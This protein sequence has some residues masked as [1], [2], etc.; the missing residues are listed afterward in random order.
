VEVGKIAVRQQ[1]LARD[2]RPGRDVLVF[3]VAQPPRHA[4]TKYDNEG[5]GGDYEKGERA[6]RER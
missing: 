1:A 6:A 3:V 5:G 2:Q 4:E